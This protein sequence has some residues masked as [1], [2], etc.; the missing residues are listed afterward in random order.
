M[1]NTKPDNNER[2]FV[3][4]LVSLEERIKREPF[5]PESEE[6]LL[7]LTKKARERAHAK[8]WIQANMAVR[9]IQITWPKLNR[10]A[11]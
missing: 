4:L 3:D 11:L 5:T 9:T 10:R 7:A 6:T 1:K 8:D 2:K